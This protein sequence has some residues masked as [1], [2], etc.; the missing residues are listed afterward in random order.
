MYEIYIY[1]YIHR[2]FIYICIYIYIYI[3]VFM[4]IPDLPLEH[5][6]QHQSF[7]ISIFK[8]MW[9]CLWCSG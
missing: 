6:N 5:F 3:D 1:V 7:K 9:V 8:K 4:Y 2:K